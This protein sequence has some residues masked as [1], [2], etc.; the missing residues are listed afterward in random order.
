M[1]SSGSA[2]HGY[3]IQLGTEFNFTAI[4]EFR[5][6]YESDDLSACRNFRIDFKRTKYMDSSGLGMLIHMK[7]YL[8]KNEGIMDE[9]RISLINCNSRIKRIFEIARFGDQFF[10]E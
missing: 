8:N 2:K 4:D 10:I 6:T 9:L 1:I 3:T 5:A 7:K